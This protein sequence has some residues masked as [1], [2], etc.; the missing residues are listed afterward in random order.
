MTT[1][2]EPTDGRTLQRQLAAQLRHRIVTGNLQPGDQLPSQKELR[3]AYGVSDNT[4][5]AAIDVLRSEGLV[6]ST[7]GKGV[8]VRQQQP[9]RRVSSTRYAD[10]LEALQTNSEQHR[11]E[12]AFT[13]DL[14]IDWDQYTVDCD[15]GEAP[16][17]NTVADHLQID[18]GVP[19][20]RR[21]M[22]M[23]ASGRAERLQTSYY[24]LDLVDGTAM[25]DP[26]Q[27]PWPGGVI[28]ELAELGVAITAVDEYVRT[29]MPTPDESYLL[30]IAGGVPVLVETRVGH[31]EARPVEVVVDMVLPGDRYVLHYHIDL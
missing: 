22:V 24:P 17:D 12:S 9:V 23:R 20:F 1:P 28:A 30:R 27:Q 14:G 26:D 2:I 6:D 3:A 16:A 29:R 8:F 11:Y 7:R 5:R 15:F 18:V 13:R 31:S 25:T 21:R 4:I 19:V 10:Q